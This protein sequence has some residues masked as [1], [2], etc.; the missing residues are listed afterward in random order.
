VSELIVRLVKTIPASRRA[1]FEAWLDADTLR[2]FMCPAEGTGV[3]RVEV[4]PRVGGSFLIVMRVGER[5]L[6][7]RGSYRLIEPDERIVFSWHSHLAGEN[8]EVT[9]TFSDAGPGQTLLTLEHR[10]LD[11]PAIAPHTGGWTHI[12][13]E[14]AAA[15]A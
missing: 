8:S 12:L 4:E 7:H 13:D 3:S 15:L 10:G 9:L 5:E 1:V 6:P 14:L 2:R 11:E